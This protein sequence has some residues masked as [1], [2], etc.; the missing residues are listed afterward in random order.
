MAQGLKE[1]VGE[2]A[3][4]VQSVLQRLREFSNEHT[5]IDDPLHGARVKAKEL[6]STPK[7]RDIANHLESLA[8][9]IA[10]IERDAAHLGV[11]E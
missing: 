2:S 5:S 7:Y 1:A 8:N 3:D 6:L 9:A 10:P 11:T 4:A